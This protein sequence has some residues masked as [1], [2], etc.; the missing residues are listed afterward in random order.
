MKQN[1]HQGI[2]IAYDAK[3]AF[4]NLTGLGNYSRLVIGTMA[5]MYP[6]HQYLLMTPRAD[7]NPRIDPILMRENVST[8]VPEG[9]VGRRVPAWWRSVTLTAELGRRGV[10][11][12][13][14][15][16]NEI[17]LTS[18]PCATVVT[19]HDLIW[20]R[21][22]QDYAAID[23]RLYEFKY[24][25]SARKATRIIAISECTKRDI[26]NDWGIDPAKI[27]VV[28]QGCDPVFSK[29]I[30]YT[31]RMRVKQA[32][33]LPDRYIVAVGTI[34]SRKNQLL[35]VRALAALDPDIH[36]VIV[37]GGRDHAYRKQVD[38]TIQQLRLGN[39]VHILS[40]VPFDDLPAIYA[41]AEFSSYTSRYE[42]F[43]IPLIESLNVGTPLIACT[44]SCLEEA[45]GPGGLY[46]DPDD[47]NGYVEAARSLLNRRYMHDQMAAA[48][49][50]HVG[51][52][53]ATTF[54]EDLMKSYNKAILDH[55][56]TDM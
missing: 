34:Q 52:F 50:R 51:R 15:L 44:G 49:K 2:T 45:G 29:I 13:H 28:Y 18:A 53:N 20:R 5:A 22:P 24:R 10:D 40:N 12:Y 41:G 14:G 39:R 1:G 17:P 23:R 27:D 4:A 38:D 16:S 8:V 33:N 42:G 6:S 19:I 54:A 35:A 43:G 56:L 25:T 31:E 37:G 46:V 55:A 36:L 32:H 9:A 3:R 21:V 30:D 47:V 7:S 48:G 26:V 11:L